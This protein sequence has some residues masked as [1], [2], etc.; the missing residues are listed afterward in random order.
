[1][2]A[3][4][5][6]HFG[7][8]SSLLGLLAAFLFVPTAGA[9]EF[10]DWSVPVN[11]NLLPNQTIPIN[12]TFDD[13][14]MA[15]SKDGLSLYF[16]SN[17]PDG[18]GDFD[19]WVTQRASVDDPWEEPFNLDAPR[20][21]GGLPCVINSSLRD[22]APNF[23][24]DGHLL[25]FHSFRTNDNCGGGDMYVAHRQNRRDDLSWEAPVNL[26]RVGRDPE[27]SL[28]C[29]VIGD[30]NFVNTPN[31]DAGPTYFQDETTGT[32]V[33]YFTRSDQPTTL[34]DFDIYTAAL[35]PD[36]TWGTIVR[37]DQLSVV[38]FR[39]TRTAIRRRDGLEMILSSERPGGLGTTPR[40]LWVS[41]RASTQDPWSIPVLLPNVNSTALDGAP[42]LSWDGTELY[43]FS[44]RPGG[45][46]GTDIYRST[47][48]KVTG[49]N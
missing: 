30:L 1:M 34:G 8:A 4:T 27:A 21:A 39:D 37:D 48:S 42:A 10:S 32:T 19:I 41:T 44:A 2:K 17:R 12:S 14:H 40:D 49:N 36:G 45:V 15:I 26:N 47:R 46:G 43:F 20:L 25:F 16:A 35:G 9:Q 33:L 31:T 22:F 28:I 24:T 18:C 7:A 29:G 13:Q 6:K 5:L 38:G 3:K 23:S 11:L